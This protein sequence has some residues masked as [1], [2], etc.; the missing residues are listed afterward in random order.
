MMVYDYFVLALCVSSL[1]IITDM[2]REPVEVRPAIFWFRVGLLA[3]IAAFTGVRTLA[4]LVDLVHTPTFFFSAW[5]T[6]VFFHVVWM[7]WYSNRKG[8]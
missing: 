1:A 7:T 2:M 3:N 8:I 5:G 4:V 6:I